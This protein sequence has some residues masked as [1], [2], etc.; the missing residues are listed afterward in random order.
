MFSELGI[1]YFILEWVIRLI[2][3]VIIPL[4]RPSQAAQSWLLL[5][6]FLPLPGLLLYAAIGRPK[7]P[8][9]RVQ[10][11]ARVQPLL[12]G[13]AAATRSV[14]LTGVPLDTAIT[15]NLAAR[16]GGFPPVG[17]NSAD[18][19]TAD[20]WYVVSYVFSGTSITIRVD[21]KLVVDAAPLDL[22]AIV[23]E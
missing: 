12:A 18:V 19:F 22:P 13:V 17:G 20:K 9:W 16:V 14:P 10:R 4:R 2:M 3:V 11:F 1:G 7:F 6:F 5:I 21:G 23:I 8:A 15:E